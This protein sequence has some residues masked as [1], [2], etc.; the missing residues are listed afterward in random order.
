[1][2]PLAP[3]ATANIKHS[4]ISSYTN[5]NLHTKGLFTSFLLPDMTCLALKKLLQG[6]H[7]KRQAKTQSEETKQLSDSAMTHVEIVK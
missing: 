1:M 7:T 4:P 6:I 2:K 3:R 5:R